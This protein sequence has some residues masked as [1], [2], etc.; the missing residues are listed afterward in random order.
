M[1]LD[2]VPGAKGLGM[3]ERTST[4][5]SR[6]SRGTLLAPAA[7]LAVLVATLAF[8]A[9]GVPRAS[10]PEYE[11]IDLGTLGGFSSAAW[12]VNN[13]GQVAGEADTPQGLR[14][15][16]L[17]DP[18]TQEMIDLGTLPPT[19]QSAALD[20]NDQGQVTGIS[21]SDGW[22][23]KAFL[24]DNGELVDIGQPPSIISAYGINNAGQVVGAFLAAPNEYRAFLWE[25]GVLTA[26]PSTLGGPPD[27]F[28]RDVNNLGEVVGSAATESAAR[29]FLWENGQMTD[30]GT[31]GGTNSAAYAVNDA[32]QVAGI[33]QRTAA[34][35]SYYPFVWEN[36][37]MIELPPLYGLANWKPWG[38]NNL[39][40][41]VGDP[42]FLYDPELGMIDV[43]DLLPAESGWSDLD[44][45]DINDAGQMVG[46][47]THN[48][49]RRAFRMTPV[50]PVIPASSIWTA[51]SMALGVVVIGSVALRR[52]R[53][54]SGESTLT[55]DAR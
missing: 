24:W 47:G 36:G 13:K 7:G 20:L 14:H 2:G 5:K 12:G 37:Q 6:S 46:I 23:D 16:F 10:F 30:L 25:D 52:G 32:G 51:L 4:L 31:L 26:I 1:R 21:T 28:G 43:H 40:Q 45:R 55:G 54:A 50:L 18:A 8:A 15:A 53:F 22:P 9:V 27:S 29:A 35:D 38:I 41:V 48:G 49:K 39:G 34:D 44:V 3:A 19:T 11:I 33:S 42:Y 17:W